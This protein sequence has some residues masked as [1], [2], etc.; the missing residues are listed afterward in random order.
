MSRRWWVERPG[1]VDVACP[2]THEKLKWAFIQML[3]GVVPV[4]TIQHLD[5]PHRDRGYSLVSVPF[6]FQDI[7]VCYVDMLRGIQLR[8]ELSHSSSFP[9]KFQAFLQDG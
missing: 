9:A 7:L 2:V 6:G 4:D 1:L 3:L 8:D 5:R